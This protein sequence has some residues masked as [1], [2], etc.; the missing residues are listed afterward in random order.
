MR[1]QFGAVLE[2]ERCEDASD[3]VR[4]DIAPEWGRSAPRMCNEVRTF[5]LAIGLFSDVPPLRHVI[6]DLA[7]QGLDQ[8]S[9]CLIG[10]AVALSNGAL[11]DGDGEAASLYTALVRELRDFEG[12]FSS[13]AL[14]ASAGPLLDDLCELDLP[15]QGSYRPRPG[16]LSDGQRRRLEHQL[17]NG[18]LV[19]IVSSE[20]S[21]Q[22]DASCRILLRH[23]RHG[24]QTHDFTL[25][26]RPD[27]A[28]DK[29]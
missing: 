17:L 8:R 24:V 18:S 15:K 27:C 6:A 4:E 28:L 7:A 9:L 2:G 5:R 26:A 16:W 29:H 13:A 20:T 14:K 1:S 25:G 11:T 22:Q 10:S 23:S 21:E 19:L 3:Q 12:L